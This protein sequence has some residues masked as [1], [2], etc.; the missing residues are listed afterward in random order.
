MHQ[1]RVNKVLDLM[2]QKNLTQ[3]IISDPSAIFYLT[4]TWIQPGERLLALYLTQTGKHKLFVN[5]L[6]PFADAIQCDKVWLN[7]NMDGIGV[8]AEYVEKDKPVAIDKN[9][10]ARFLIGLIDKKAGSAF[11]NGSEIVDRVR[12]VKDAEEIKLMRE[13]SRLN[14]LAIG[15]VI[16]LMKEDY[17]E[18][19]VERKLS[20]IWEELGADGHS[21]EPIIGYGANAAD[22]HH[23]ITK[24]AHK[25]PGDSIVIDKGCLYKSYCSDMTRTVFYKS[26][27][28]EGR[29]VYEITRD[30]NLK[31]IDKVKPGVTFAELDAAARDYITDH[32][33]GKYFTHRLGHSIGIDI[34]EP[35]DVSAANTEQV[36]PGRIFS[37]EPGIYL[38]GN[39][40]VRV[41]DLVLVTEDGCEVLNHF[42][43]DLIVVE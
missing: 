25:K 42:T 4:G 15:R 39:L 22:P 30:A 8:L 2:A 11:V 12:M 23:S 7:D 3:M 36:V 26:V 19:E 34:H 41:E 31:A 9:W 16:E 27:S 1:E 40:G 14:D 13:A 43:K 17:D 33:Y 35:G 32:G 21:F 10:P 29:K 20:E 5:E 18:V 28:D 37:I 38:P 6:F 24:G